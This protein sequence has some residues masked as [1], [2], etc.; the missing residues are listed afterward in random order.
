LR[1]GRDDFHYVT[2]SVG[3]DSA[4]GAQDRLS[5]ST[6]PQVKVTMEMDSGVVSKSTSVRAANGQAGGG[7]ERTAIGNVPVKILSVHD[8]R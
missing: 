8:L 1:G 5:L 7:T 6:T 2:D 3:T 4:L